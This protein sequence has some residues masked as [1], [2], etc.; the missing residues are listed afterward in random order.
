VGQR[1]GLPVLEGASRD[2]SDSRGPGSPVVCLLGT[3]TWWNP[4]LA[5]VVLFVAAIPLAGAIAW[6]GFSQ[7]LSKA[8]TTTLAALIWAVSPPLLLAL[9]MVGS[10]QS[11]RCWRFPGCSEPW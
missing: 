3:L 5:L 1:L 6:W 11:C 4:N 9:P 8:W 7:V 10:E 2:S